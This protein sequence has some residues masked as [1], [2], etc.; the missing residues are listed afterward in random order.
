MTIKFRED[1]VILD[2]RCIDLEARIVINLEKLYLSAKKLNLKN[3][4]H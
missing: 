3:L 1:P 4:K 2:P